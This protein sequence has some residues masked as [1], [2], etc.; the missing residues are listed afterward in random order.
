LL[1]KKVSFDSSAKVSFWQYILQNQ[2]LRQSG[3]FVTADSGRRRPRLGRRKLR[4]GAGNEP[5]FAG[6]HKL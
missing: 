6:G 3:H 2:P 1:L 4:R 5:A